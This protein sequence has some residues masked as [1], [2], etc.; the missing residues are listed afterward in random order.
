MGYNYTMYTQHITS[1]V[2]YCCVSPP[3]PCGRIFCVVHGSHASGYQSPGNSRKVLGG[4]DLEFYFQNR[5]YLLGAQCE[6]PVVFGSTQIVGEKLP[7]KITK[8]KQ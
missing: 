3:S 1:T 5:K 6:V 7:K 8:I 4:P 2:C